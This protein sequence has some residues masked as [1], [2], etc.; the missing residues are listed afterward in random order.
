[1]RFGSIGDST[2]SARLNGKWFGW[3]SSNEGA[4]KS[5]PLSFYIT[6]TFWRAAYVQAAR[7]SIISQL[8][9]FVKQ[10]I[11]KIFFIFF[12]QNP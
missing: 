7:I 9:Q 4:E 10:K 2:I 8:E 11:E 5:A 6:K 3:S 12:S 1:V